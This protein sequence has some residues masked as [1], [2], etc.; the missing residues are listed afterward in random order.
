MTTLTLRLHGV[1][2]EILE[3]MVQAGLAETRTEAVR[4]A[5]LQFGRSSGL[6][7]EVAL[8]E[9]LQRSAARKPLSDRKILDG[10]GRARG[11]RG[12]RR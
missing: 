6:I 4:I 10:I 8:F 7:D 11:E 9:A 2:A 1:Q 3:R 12:R 5:L